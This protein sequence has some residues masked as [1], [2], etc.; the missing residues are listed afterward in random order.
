ML[1][2]PARFKLPR[3]RATV[4]L[5]HMKLP[6]MIELSIGDTI[7]MNRQDAKNAKKRTREKTDQMADCR[8]PVAWHHFSLFSCFSLAFLALWRFILIVLVISFSLV[9]VSNAFAGDNKNR[10]QALFLLSQWKQSQKWSE[11]FSVQ[12]NTTFR[13]ITPVKEPHPSNRSEVEI[14]KMDTCLNI[15]GF[16]YN[17]AAEKVKSSQKISI[18][19]NTK[20]GLVLGHEIQ[21][22]PKAAV[23]TEKPGNMLYRYLSDINMASALDG[24]ILEADG[25]CLSEIM[26]EANDL[27][28]VRTELIDS[29]TCQKISSKTVY[30]NVELWLDEKN[31]YLP[32]K[33]IFTREPE[34]LCSQG[35]K[36]R[37]S[38]MYGIGQGDF[39]EVYINSWSCALDQVEIGESG[40]LFPIKGRLLTNYSLSNGQRSSGEY[41]YKR[42]KFNPTPD[43]SERDFEI[44]LPNGM[45][46]SN[47][48]DPDSGVVYEWRHGNVVPAYSD[49]SG[50]ATGRWFGGSKLIL[51]LWL[52]TGLILLFVSLW[53][54]RRYKKA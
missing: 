32:R 36:L 43:L 39:R 21:K 7:K 29:Y 11:K 9:F 42:T 35:K 17:L 19:V 16:V 48:D 28:F 26:S 20:L 8:I 37:E 22:Q 5:L 18:V 52:G 30:G 45:R 34:S 40:F 12:V 2:S 23:V 1:S 6:T 4:G 53:Y 3:L 33:Y 31:G 38:N 51:L 27:T 44:D 10:E 54:L 50:S 46:I 49:F 47:Q 13:A 41:I 14:K 24:Y 25:K 15:S